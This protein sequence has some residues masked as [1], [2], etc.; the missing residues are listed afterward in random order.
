MSVEFLVRL[1]I[2]GDGNDCI[3]DLLEQKLACQ[4]GLKKKRFVMQLVKGDAPR[5][6][7]VLALIYLYGWGVNANVRRAKE[8]LQLSECPM[9]RYK[10]LVLQRNSK[11]VVDEIVKPK[12]G[13]SDVRLLMYAARMPYGRARKSTLLKKAAIRGC[14]RAQH[15]LATK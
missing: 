8:L 4:M 10:Y 5:K 6:I 1:F 15:L 9:A 12:Y 14:V 13:E 2:K 7:Y 3:A 11:K